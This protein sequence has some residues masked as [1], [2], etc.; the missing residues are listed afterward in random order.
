[1]VIPKDRELKA[2]LLKYLAGCPGH[3]AH[4]PQC[5]TALEPF[6][7][8]LTVDEVTQRYRASVSKWAN[9]FSWNT[10]RRRPLHRRCG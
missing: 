2:A 4:A 5:C 7:P 8:D 10:A 3:R 6:F 9:S 1:M